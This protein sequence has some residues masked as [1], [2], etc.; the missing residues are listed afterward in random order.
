MADTAVKPYCQHLRTKRYYISDAPPA[1]YLAEETATTGY[2][3]LRTMG[4]IGPDDG[5]ASPGRCTVARPCYRE[6]GGMDPA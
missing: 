1:T 4:T 6:I 3:C 5:F 2:W